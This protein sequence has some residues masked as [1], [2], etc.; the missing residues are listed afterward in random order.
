MIPFVLFAAISAS[1]GDLTAASDATSLVSVGPDRSAPPPIRPP[2]PLDLPEPEV[3]EVR[4]GVRVHLV[5]VPEVR[6]VS[7]AVWL[8]RGSLDLDGAPT[9]AAALTGWLQ[10]VATETHDS[11]ELEILQDLTDTRVMSSA[12]ALRRT[13]ID[14]ETPRENLADG[15]TLLAEVLEAPTYPNKDLKQVKQLR[16]FWYTVEAPS[17][18]KAVTSQLAEHAW[19]PA[20]TPWGMRPDLDGLDALKRADLRARHA[21]LLA[22]SP[23]TLMLVGDVTRA[24]LEPLLTRTLGDVGTPG[25]EGAVPEF[26]PTPGL[27]VYAADMPG[28]EQAT[29]MVRTDAPSRTHADR[30]PFEVVNWALGGH[31]MSRLN[32]NLREEKGFT[33]GAGSGYRIRD[34]HG[35]WTA[36]V[37]V[38]VEN[39]GATLQEIQHEVTRVRDAGI[40]DDEIDAAWKEWVGGW[41]GVQQTASSAFGFYG[42]LFEDGLSV[43]TARADLD[44]LAALDP[45]ATRAVAQRWFAADGPWMWV[46]VGDREKIAPQLDALGVEVEWVAPHDAILGAF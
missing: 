1:A 40:A 44:A 2:V 41:N 14:L 21:Q 13:R 26:T 32:A 38:K 46:V 7:G 6:K 42:R 37:T 35:A 12:P 22:E 5:T 31:F 8:H 43:Q 24:D 29:V 18:Q 45:D 11:V 10:D 30:L 4:P 34:T 9:M 15:L 17:S 19:Y 33:Y 23:I 28:Q 20:D 39:V 16:H 27:R 3:W 36:Q 25:E